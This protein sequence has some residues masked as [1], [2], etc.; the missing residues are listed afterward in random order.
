MSLT[1]PKAGLGVLPLIFILGLWE[2]SRK[3]NTTFVGVL[4]PRVLPVYDE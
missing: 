2:Y 4:P 3:Y 1:T